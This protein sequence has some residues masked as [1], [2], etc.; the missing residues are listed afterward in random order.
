[1]FLLMQIRMKVIRIRKI[2]NDD[3]QAMDDE[4]ILRNETNILKNKKKSRFRE[5]FPAPSGNAHV[6]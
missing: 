2:L 1:M 4:Y 6:R 3:Y 5:F